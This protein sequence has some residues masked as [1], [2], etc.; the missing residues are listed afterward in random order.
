MKCLQIYFPFEAHN[1]H[2]ARYLRHITD[3]H[4]ETD[5]V[6]ANNNNIVDDDAAGE[7]ESL[8]KC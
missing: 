2:S 4:G 1:L 6:H 3:T 5:M 7:G 8:G